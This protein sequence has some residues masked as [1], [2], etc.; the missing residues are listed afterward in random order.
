MHVCAIVFIL[1]VQGRIPTCGFAYNVGCVGV[2]VWVRVLLVM[3]VCALL[4]E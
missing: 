3:S 2:C 1:Y 4:R